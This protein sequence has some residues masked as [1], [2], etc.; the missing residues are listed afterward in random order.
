MASGSDLANSNVADVFNSIT[1]II[2]TGVPILVLLI[3][4]VLSRRFGKKAVAVAGFGLTAISTLAFS[5]LRPTDVGG[6][7]ALTI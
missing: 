1:N 4:P 6:M 2:S 7:I 5:L 3:S